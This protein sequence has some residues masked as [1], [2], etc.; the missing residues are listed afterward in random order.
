MA[1]VQASVRAFAT[2]STSP[3]ALCSRVNSVLCANI[4]SGKFVTL[5]YGVLDSE[6][7]WFHY[8][9]AGHLLPILIQGKGDVTELRNGGA[10]VGVFPEWKYEDS[11]VQ[12]NPGDRLLLFTDGITEAGLPGGEEFGEERLVAGARTYAGKSTSELKSGLLSDV[13]QFC[14]S[15]FRDD[16]TL[17]VISALPSSRNNPKPDVEVCAAV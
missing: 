10:V 8:T 7:G 5:F 2:E 3:S 9:N 1:N 15:Q 11:V 17:I 16:A 14:A 6:G 4:A 12:L 13:N